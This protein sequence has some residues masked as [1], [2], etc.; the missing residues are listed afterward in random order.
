MA[1]FLIKDEYFNPTDTLTCGQIFRYNITDRGYVVF[2]QD[3]S[4]HIYAEGNDWAV[5]TD[6]AE[7]FKNFFDLTTD[8]SMMAN[9]LSKTSELMQK[10]VNKGKG[11]RILRQDLYEMIISFMISANNNIKRIQLIID[12]MCTRLGKP[13]KDGYAFPS[14]KDLASQDKSFFEEIGAGYRADYL[15]HTCKRLYNDFDFDALKQMD[16]QTARKTLCGLKGVGPKVADCILL[17]GMGKGDVFPV[18]TWIKKIYH[19]A[20]ETGLPDDK[21]HSFFVDMFKDLSGL[22]QQYLF[23]FYRTMDK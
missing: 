13:I 3:K 20:F 19:D 12:R 9:T 16:T 21:I 15:A 6:D 1:V 8:Y 10:A 2:S 7:Y 23:Y 5:E 4:A 14:I 17:F 18:D 11:I 22:A